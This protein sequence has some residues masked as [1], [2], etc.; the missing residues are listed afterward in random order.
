MGR[1]KKNIIIGFGAVV[2]AITIIL[3]L[4]IL[5]PKI[6]QR[7]ERT[8]NIEKLL[9]K[10]KNGRLKNNKED[11]DVAQSGLMGL[12]ETEKYSDAERIARKYLKIYPYGAAYCEF[13]QDALEGQ[14][15]W[16]EAARANIDFS[17]KYWKIVNITTKK[18]MFYTRM[19]K[20]KGKLSPDM[21]K[22][23]EKFME[24][25]EANEKVYKKLEKDRKNKSLKKDKVVIEKLKK[26]GASNETFFI[27]YM[28]YLI[29]TKQKDK[30]EKYLA[31]YQKDDK[32]DDMS[33]SYIVSYKEIERLKK[34]LAKL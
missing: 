15:K 22:E 25:I 28:D 21:K 4:S 3:M 16:D 30:A 5:V 24:D 17:R 10:E 34:E 32:K 14:N 8:R 18:Y 19:K 31:A 11:W 12:I 26:K 23:A 7:I 29:Q 6:R 1:K 20:A 27:I 2:A 33:S 13:L 9:E